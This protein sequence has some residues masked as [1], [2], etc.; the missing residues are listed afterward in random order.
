MEVVW[1]YVANV[2]RYFGCF[3]ERERERA[4]ICYCGFPLSVLCLFVVS[5]TTV[6]YNHNPQVSRKV[7]AVV[8]IST[9]GNSILV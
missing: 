3:F 9:A 7:A 1:I 8:N 4:R 5:L 2:S 6:K